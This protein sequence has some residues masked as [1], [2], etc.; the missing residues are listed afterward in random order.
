MQGAVKRTPRAVVRQQA[1]DNLISRG[2]CCHYVYVTRSLLCYH[3]CW[4]RTTCRP[5]Y[6]LT[7]HFLSISQQSLAMLEKYEEGWSQE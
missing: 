2:R 1:G 6:P 7:N 4:G 3:L 5:E